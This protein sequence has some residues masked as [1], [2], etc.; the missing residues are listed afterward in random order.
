MP[1]EEFVGKV[2]DLLPHGCDPD[3]R[4]RMD[5]REGTRHVGCW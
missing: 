4:I 3:G 5:E 1:A 2:L